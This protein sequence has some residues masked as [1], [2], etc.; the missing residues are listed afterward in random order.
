[1]KEILKNSFIEKIKQREKMPLSETLRIAAGRKATT[2][3]F[4]RAIVAGVLVVCILA[5]NM[6]R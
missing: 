2:S 1:M 4:A 5:I 6:I 3:I